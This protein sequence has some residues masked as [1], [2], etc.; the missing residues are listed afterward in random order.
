MN[1]CN[2]LR[3]SD[4]NVSQR[5]RKS[6]PDD[7]AKLKTETK[8]VHF[9]IGESDIANAQITEILADGGVVL[10]RTWAAAFSYIRGITLEQVSCLKKIYNSYY[11]SPI[12]IRRDIEEHNSAGY[13]FF[14]Y[15]Y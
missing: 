12:D 11:N 1:F 6:Y 15:I 2:Y 9:I 7:A 3:Q 14:V 5:S 4:S 8:K 10:T 13:G